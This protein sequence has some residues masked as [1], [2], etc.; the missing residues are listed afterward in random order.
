MA[1]Q[2]PNLVLDIAAISVR[3]LEAQE[4]GP[5]ARTVARDLAALLPASAV[6][7]YLLSETDEGEVWT[8]YG[9]VG[10]AAPD[11][12]VPLDAGT[13]GILATSRNPL[14]FAG[15]NLIREQYAHLNVRKTLLSLGYL[16]LAANGSLIGAIEILSF[17]E[18]LTEAHLD[19]LQGVA[20]VAGP[21]LTAARQYELERHHSL[22]SIT[23]LTHFYDIEK[24]F[25]STIEMD[26]LRS[27]DRV[28]DLRDPRVPGASMCGWCKAMAAFCSCIKQATIRLPGK[29]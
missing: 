27:P 15:R 29:A 17:D 9:T 25:S 2:S 5:R 12:T 4:V 20:E 24:V 10:D 3:L 7:V 14:L 1:T 8:V 6:N 26:Q 13:L 23:R 18:P 28:E 11:E 21:A 16:P 22:T 19:I